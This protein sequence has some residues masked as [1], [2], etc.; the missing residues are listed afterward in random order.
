LLYVRHQT[1]LQKRRASAS[2]SRGREQTI[3]STVKASQIDPVHSAASP[4]V[5]SP[6]LQ[7]PSRSP[8][9]SACGTP[10]LVRCQ[11]RLLQDNIPDDCNDVDTWTVGHLRNE[12][13]NPMTKEKMLRIRYVTGEEEVVCNGAVHRMQ[14]VVLPPAQSRRPGSADAGCRH[15]SSPPPAYDGHDSSASEPRTDTSIMSENE[16]DLDS[17]ATLSDAAVGLVTNCTEGRR[18]SCNQTPA[19]SDSTISERQWVA[20]KRERQWEGT[21][22]IQHPSG[23]RS[24]GEGNSTAMSGDGA[25]HRREVQRGRCGRGA[26]WRGRTTG[27]TAEN[28]PATGCTRKRRARSDSCL[29]SVLADP[30][31]QLV[32]TRRWLRTRGVKARIHGI[33]VLPPK[34]SG[35]WGWAVIRDR[36]ESRLSEREGCLY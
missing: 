1:P 6:S 34:Y 25:V 36:A 3:L 31:F 22:D 33:I 20:S 30:P 12:S 16:S 29:H 14:M 11:R 18:D 10:E 26:A 13:I 17:E 28:G 9:H 5:S 35:E 32:G 4:Q 2:T 21:D 19:A 7:T 24:G 23:G 15:Q 8:A 27:V